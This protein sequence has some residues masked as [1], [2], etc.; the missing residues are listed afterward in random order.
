MEHKNMR[1]AYKNECLDEPQKCLTC[2]NNLSLKRSY[3]REDSY[4]KK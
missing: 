4:I 3:Y 1:C 2:K